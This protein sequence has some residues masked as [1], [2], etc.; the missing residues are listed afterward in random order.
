[1]PDQLP[2]GMGTTGIDCFISNGLPMFF[3]I[4]EE[5][6]REGGGGYSRYK[7]TTK[8]YS[9]SKLVLT[10]IIYVCPQRPNFT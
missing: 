6:R 5:T 10:Q 8:H 3:H 1:M 2:V 9:N 7:I 4:L